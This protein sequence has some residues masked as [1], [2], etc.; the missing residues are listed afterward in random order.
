MGVQTIAGSPELAEKIKK[1]RNEIGLTIEEAAQKSGVGIKTW[2]R[3]EAG[4]SI[5]K[6]KYA[7]I[8]RAL[9]WSRAYHEDG[10]DTKHLTLDQY[11]AYEGWSSYLEICFGELAAASFAVGIDILADHLAD[12]LMLL[13]RMPKGTHIGQLEMSWLEGTLP[14]Q[15]LMNYNYEFLYL[16]NTVVIRLRELAKE[17]SEI[18]VHSVLEELVIYLIVEE[19]RIYF[20]AVEMEESKKNWDYWEYDLFGDM[21]IMLFLYSD[22]FLE[23]SD[24]YHFTNWNKMQ[25][26]MPE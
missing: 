2:C 11:R 8:C 15:F 14:Q 17:G 26:Y 20:E 18:V 21:D 24:T 12:D 16:M 6:D 3:Y 22:F 4:G 23:E 1:R 25:F 5:R 10:D 7:G 19:S 9:E 13:S